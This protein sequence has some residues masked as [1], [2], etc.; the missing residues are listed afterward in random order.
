MTQPRTHSDSLAVF[1]GIVLI[2]LT[3]A[4]AP[5]AGATTTS[6]VIS[7]ANTDIEVGETTTVS[8]VVDQVDGGVGAW[9]GTLNVTGDSA[10]KIRGVQLHGDPGLRTV[11][12]SDSNESVYFDGA[13]A[14]TNQSGS[15]AI[16]S[17]TLEATATGESGLDLTMEAVGDERGNSYTITETVDGQVTVGN[18]V[19]GNDST[20][21]SKSGSQETS[22]EADSSSTGTATLTPASAASPSQDTKTATGTITA[23]GATDASTPPTKTTSQ[24]ARESDPESG[25]ESAK[26][27]KTDAPGFTV[28]ATCVGILYFAVAIGQRR[29]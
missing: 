3:V 2:A 4:V 27:T 7:P 25:S 15:V 23:S 10:I 13:L 8:V 22:N 24:S 20:G 12:I 19:N 9:A 14:D 29:E 18:P 17:V 28:L 16:V 1:S 11:N 26:T 6:V 21:E 5:V